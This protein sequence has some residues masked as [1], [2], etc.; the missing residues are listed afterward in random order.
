[1]LY[2]CL[3][4]VRPFQAD[5]LYGVFHA[6]VAGA[7]ARPRERRPELDAEFEAV[8]LRAMNVS[9]D[10]RF[11]S[12]TALGRAL[13]PFASERGRMLW[14]EAFGS[15]QPPSPAGAPGVVVERDRAG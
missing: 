9:P 3:T 8:V 1:M 6:I 12:V 11:P 5:S 2:E 7:P 4:G 10:G 15:S 14:R 13:W